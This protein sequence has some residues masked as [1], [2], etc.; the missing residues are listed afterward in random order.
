MG[1]IE[2]C[3]D[4]KKIVGGDERQNWISPFTQFIRAHF[5]L[6]SPFFS[7]IFIASPFLFFHC[8]S[9]QRFHHSLIRKEGGIYA[10][11]NQISKWEIFPNLRLK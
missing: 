7:S 6:I 2:E 8:S 11:N 9:G 5:F 1:E 3:N 4:P 10:Q